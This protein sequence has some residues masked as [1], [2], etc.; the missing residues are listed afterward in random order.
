MISNRSFDQVYKSVQKG[1]K[2][3]KQIEKQQKKM[4]FLPSF[5]E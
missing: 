4:T 5:V 3:K 1:E 2:Y